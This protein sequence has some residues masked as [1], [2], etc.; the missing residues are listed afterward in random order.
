MRTFCTCGEDLFWQKR[1]KK[2][3]KTPP[4]HMWGLDFV[5]SRRLSC[6]LILISFYLFPPPPHSSQYRL[7]VK[8]SSHSVKNNLQ[9]TK[10]VKQKT[11]HLPNIVKNKTCKCKNKWAKSKCNNIQVAIHLSHDA[12]ERPAAAVECVFCT[13]AAQTPEQPLPL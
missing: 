11:Q 3:T 8:C 2:K 9:R 1:K 10:S 7:M 12:H 13:S 6:L 4:R 5:T